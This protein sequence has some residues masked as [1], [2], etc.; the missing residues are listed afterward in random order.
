MIPESLQLQ[1]QGTSNFEVVEEIH[2]ERQGASHLREGAAASLTQ[3]D[4]V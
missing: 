4:V 2:V 1:N 3:T